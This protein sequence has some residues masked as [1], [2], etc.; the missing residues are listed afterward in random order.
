MPVLVKSE[1][2]PTVRGGSPLRRARTRGVVGDGVPVHAPRGLHGPRREKG[3]SER[4]LIPSPARSRGAGLRTIGLRTGISRRPRM[5]CAMASPH[6]GGPYIIPLAQSTLNGGFRGSRQ[7]ACSSQ[8]GSIH[9]VGRQSPRDRGGRGRYI[10][11]DSRARNIAHSGNFPFSAIQFRIWVES[12][13]TWKIAQ[14]AV[15]RLPAKEKPCSA[16]RRADPSAG[17]QLPPNQ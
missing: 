7:P 3:R 2:T 12:F 11:A 9:V 16:G 14:F 10:A 4:N 15:P 8:C 17:L 13:L 6:A 1:S 5:A